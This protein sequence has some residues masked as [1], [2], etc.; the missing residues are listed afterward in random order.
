MSEERSMLKLVDAHSTVDG[1]ITIR[2][3]ILTHSE[4]G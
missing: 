4:P 1:D 3:F 2:C